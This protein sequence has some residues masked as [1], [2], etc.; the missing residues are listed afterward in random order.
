MRDI[1]KYQVA[2]EAEL[3]KMVLEV[4]RLISDAWQPF[5]GLQVVVPVIAEGVAPLFSQAMV[6][7]A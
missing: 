3:E 7:Y 6:K 4:N 1:A 5:G 2:A